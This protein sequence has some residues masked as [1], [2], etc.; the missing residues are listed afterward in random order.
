MQKLILTLL[1]AS[2][3]LVGCNQPEQTTDTEPEP[4]L[5]HIRL[6]MGYI[7]SIQYAP[8][9]V[10]ADKNYFKEAGIE[11][12]FDYKPETDGVALVGA[13]ELPFAIVSGEQVLL[14][15]AQELPVIN[16]MG[17][18]KD[19]P[20]SIISLKDRGINS[21]EDLKGKRIG[22]PG[23]YGASYVG[24]RAFLNAVGIS[25]SDVTL[26]SIGFNQVEAL[27]SGQEDAVVVYTNN[28]PVQLRSR[29]YELTEFLVRD[30]VTLASNGIITSEKMIAE[31]PDLVGR[32]VR[33]VLRGLKD[34]IADP[35]EAYEISKIYVQGL[36]QQDQALQMDILN[37]S[38]ALWQSNPLGFSRPEAWE[39]M[40][41]VLLNM[42]LLSEP[43]D[44]NKAFTNNFVQ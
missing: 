6:P 3:L 4:E 35:N 25:E 28:E 17:W 31:N 18:W 8:F 13:G 26:D 41:Q 9:Y 42:E 24:L 44:L 2:L 12:E 27:V 33:A 11:I 7:P 10:A 1:I 19:Y 16:V 43:V 22:L 38:I 15:R 14:A 23:P 20:V 40:M 37:T 36:A 39:N 30:Y 5:V 34:A 21:P 29:G 32:F